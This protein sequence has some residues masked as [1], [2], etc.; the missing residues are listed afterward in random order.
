MLQVARQRLRG[1]LFQNLDPPVPWTALGLGGS[2]RVFR[3]AAALSRAASGPHGTSRHS[4]LLPWWHLCGSQVAPLSGR[5]PP[6]R[7]SALL[8]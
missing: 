4:L 7:G 3:A 1:G 2:V 5:S 6:K 8:S